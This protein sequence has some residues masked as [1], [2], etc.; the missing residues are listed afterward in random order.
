MP[1]KE[2]IRKEPLTASNSLVFF[3]YAL[4]GESCFSTKLTGDTEKSSKQKNKCISFCTVRA[5]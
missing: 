3:F 1:S 2:S 4:Q 5:K